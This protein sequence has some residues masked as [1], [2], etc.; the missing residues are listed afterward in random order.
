MILDQI[1]W[2]DCL[3][4]LLCLV[5]QLPI[6]VGLFETIKCGLT[7]LPFLLL[8][9][10]Y[11]L[12]RERYFTRHDQKNPFVRQATLFQDLVIRC[13]RYAFARIPASIGKVF[14]S[15]PVALPFFYFRLLRNGHFHC[16]TF[17]REIHREGFSGIYM[18]HDETAR[19]DIVVYYC[20]GGG[21]S[22]GSAY[23]YMEFCMAWLDLLKAAGYENPALLALEYTLV[24]EATYPTQVQEAL[25]GYKWLLTIAPSP[26]RIVLA[27]DSAGA[28]LIL[29]L[30][31]CLSNYTS[32]RNKMPGLAIPISPWT[33]II[34]SKNRNTPSDYLDADSLRLYGQQYISTHASADDAMVS[35]GRCQDLSWWRRASPTQGW[36]FIYGA[37]EVF[38]PEARDLVGL[39]KKSGSKVEAYEEKGWIHAWPVVKLFLCNSRVERVSGLQ[40]MVDVVVERLP[41]EKI[42]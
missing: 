8:R 6:K 20:H 13:V 2:S 19:P 38:A 25:A 34:S 40:R 29:S 12:V 5:P 24:P 28:T 15:K 33:A 41:P 18:I 9:L 36:Y 10:P 14:F 21:F 23:F 42:D 30:L 17:W 35:P 37:E 31:L 22:M 1:A 3:V 26:E 16:P 7:A 11:Q 32:L 39:L 4:F 27:G